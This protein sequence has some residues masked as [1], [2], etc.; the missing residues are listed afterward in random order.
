MVQCVQSI[1]QSIMN[2]YNGAVVHRR[3]S[4]SEAPEGTLHHQQRV[5]RCVF[6]RHVNCEVVMAD[7]TGVGRLF[8]VVVAATANAL[9]DVLMDVC[10][11]I[12]KPAPDDRC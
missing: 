10:G 8:Q 12:K 7:L 5:K 1:N 2:L 4:K 3:N 11:F 9:S 6:R